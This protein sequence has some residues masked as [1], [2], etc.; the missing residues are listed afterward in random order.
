MKL[1]KYLKISVI[2]TVFIIN[3]FAAPDISFCGEKNEKIVNVL[4]ISQYPGVANSGDA[5]LLKVRT[6]KKILKILGMAYD[7]EINFFQKSNA[8]NEY[9]ALLGTDIDQKEELT[10]LSLNI[11]YDDETDSDHTFDIKL[12]IIE[13]P[14][15]KL[16]L[17]KKMVEPPEEILVRIAKEREMVGAILS[18]I[19]AEP[20]FDSA[21]IMPLNT[22]ITSNFGKRRILNGIPKSPHSGIDMKG[23]V[24][25]TVK[26]SNNGVVVF[27]GELYYTGNTLIIDHGLGIFTTYFHLSK[28][29]KS[30]NDIIRQGEAIGEVGMTGR[31]T[32]PHLH[33]GVKLNGFYVNPLSIISLTKD[34][35]KTK[36]QNGQ[37]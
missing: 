25:K 31:A 8:E 2:I 3:L 21:F 23:N 4:E 16:T 24:G 9:Y 5:V 18:K 17:P 1:Q 20:L 19:T 27:T 10:K 29:Y 28:I 36:D 15:E 6:L 33:F 11:I 7:R 26:S 32:G 14:A 12:K 35:F 13:H 34:V 30:E 37:N 22:V